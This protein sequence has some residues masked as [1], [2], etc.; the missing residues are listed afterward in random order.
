MHKLIAL[1]LVPGAQF[2]D[3]LKRAWENGDAVLPVDQRLP[4]PAKAALLGAMRPSVIIREHIT[5]A[6]DGG[7]PVCAGDAVVVATSGTT[8]VPKGVVL[9]HDAISASAHATSARLSIDP[10]RDRWLACLPLA[11]IGGLSVVTRA[12]HTDTP[13]TVLPGFDPVQVDAAAASGHTCVSLVVATLPRVDITKWRTILLGGSAMPSNTAHNIVKTYGMTET[14][15][16]VVYDGVALDGVEIES[17]DGELWIRCAMLLRAYRMLANPADRNSLSPEGVNP[18]TADGWFCTG[19]AGTVDTDG[20]VRVVGRLG[21][22]I[23]TG[24]EKVWPDSVERA[25][26]ASPKVR[27]VAVVGT[28]DSTWGHRVVAFV[29]AS[30]TANPPT[31]DYLRELTKRDLP[32]YCAPQQVIVVN[33]FPR[34]GSGKIQ[35]T[36]LQTR[37]ASEPT[38]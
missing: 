4:P 18:L 37:L 9:T 23:V 20:T 15:S 14:G 32:A 7:V 6:I 3:E 30:D 19:D 34:T 33:E 2:V 24:G 11:H 10:D 22:V 29:I 35:R 8:G 36:V 27:E 25:L 5:S 17:R 26:L 12:F 21:D 13:L 31:L 38:N 1:D 16:G 28:P